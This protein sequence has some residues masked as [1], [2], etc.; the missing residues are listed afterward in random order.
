MLTKQ[1]KEEELSYAYAHIVAAIA[2]FSCEKVAV[3]MDGI[4]I[5]IRAKGKITP[6]ATLLSPSIEIQLK[7]TINWKFN[8]TKDAI[9]YR[10]KIKNYLRLIGH[11]AVRRLLVVLCLP[12]DEDQWIAQEEDGLIIKS[13]AYWMNL[14]G[15]PEIKQET[16]T[17]KIPKQNVF[18]PKALSH[19]MGLLAEQKDL[20]L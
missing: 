12:R 11:T 1:L 5:V 7:A 8:K 13:C 17:V 19:L 14:R 10:L 16:I 4:D 3:D 15:L 6:D 20:P 9:S 18:S 2:G